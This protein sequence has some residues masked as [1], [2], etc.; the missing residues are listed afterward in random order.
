M[1]ASFLLQMGQQALASLVN[2]GLL[3]ILNFQTN[4]K[5]FMDFFLKF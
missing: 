3:N 5:E 2:E 4:F 1:E